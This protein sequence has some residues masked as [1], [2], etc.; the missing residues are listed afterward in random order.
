MKNKTL[1][2]P[3]FLVLTALFFGCVTGQSRDS[4]VD[5][6]PPPVQTTPAPLESAKNTNAPPESAKNTN[7]P[8][9][10]SRRQGVPLQPVTRPMLEMIHQSG[11]DIKGVPS[12]I[13]DSI[14]LEYSKT[15]QNLEITERGEVIL[16]E[17]AVQNR[18][19][20][21]KETSG[22]LVAVNYDADGR[23]LLAM[24]FDENDGA[25]PLI[26]RE[27]DR[28]RSFYLMHYVLG[29]RE[30][31]LHYGQ[32]LYDLQLGESIPRLQ[33][34]FEETLESRPET[35]TLQGRRIIFRTEDSL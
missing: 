23:M 5:E 7:P 11:N 16:K 29:G 1:V 8:V 3:I 14:S 28:D 17:V 35:R 25:Y 18:I 20:I 19:N 26:F 4:T 24:N 32:E 33:I 2:F 15:T 6:T 27:G 13:S 12:F 21:N 9:N 31:K 10:N 30:R 22:T 34:R